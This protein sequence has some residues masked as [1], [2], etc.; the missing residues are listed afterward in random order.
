MSDEGQT[1]NHQTPSGW[2]DAQDSLA[3]ASGLSV[4]LVEGHQPPAL[5][6]SNNN[7]ICH[8][9]QSSPKHV[10]LCDP[11]CGVAFERALKAE[12]VTHYR[13]HAGLHCFAMPVNPG[14]GRQ[15][16]VI[17]GRAFLTSA[18]YRA[19]AERFR[20]G[21]LQDLLSSEIFKNVIFASR[22]DL[23][24]LA[25]RIEEAV[26]ELSGEQRLD[27]RTAQVVVSPPEAVREIKAPEAPRKVK[28]EKQTTDSAA[29][30]QAVSQDANA[31]RTLLQN[32]YFPAESEFKD[33]CSAALEVLSGKHQLTS[34]ALLLRDHGTFIRACGKG[35]FNDIQIHIEI[36]SKDARLF[37][38]ARAGTSLIL[39]ESDEG[40]KPAGTIRKR[41]ADAPERTAE[42]FP[43]IVGDEVKAAILIGDSALTDERRRA[44][45]TYCREIALPLEVLRLRHELMQRVRF[46]EH[47]Q[48]F[49][50]QI[51]TVNPDE[52]YDAILRMST[53]L[54]H[55]ERSSLLL[56]DEA[57]NELAV[58]AAVGPRADVAKETRVRMGEGISGSVLFDGRPL[59]V[60]DVE[61]GGHTPA[62]EERDYKTKSFISYPISIGG[63]KVGVL[64]VTDKAG[65]G[66]YDD[67]DLS[68]IESIAPQMAMA[69]DRAEWQEKANQFQ[70][71]SITD[72]LTGL[73]NRRY[74]IERLAEELKRSKRQEY[75]MSFMMID[76]D[77]F[78]IY[79]DHNGHQAGDLALEMTAQCLKSALRGADVASRYGGEEF[80]I[81]LPQTTLE[82]AT[83]IAE[84]IQRRVLRM[85]F[86]HGKAQPLG[87]VT[88][89]I[90]ISAFQ[91]GVDTPETIIEAAD[92]ALYLAKSRGKN[93]IEPFGS[94]ATE[95]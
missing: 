67:I 46:T 85:H 82:E 26:G 20:V 47:L 71:M 72:P 66:A 32:R 11:Y 84:R 55:A 60:R 90:G 63:R 74:L 56:L 15:L 30:K 48:S 3:A 28:A 76:I 6:V 88:V 68:L 39:R 19:L 78:K 81:L 64:N 41:I 79:N 2:T 57:T 51:N 92:R 34:L 75:P 5:E 16:A 17:G 21:D 91:Q 61:S 58:K 70:L 59:V 94:S 25:R 65:G 95:A 27:E 22:Q 24:D 62:P 40:F 14:V 12:G 7:S 50:E 4:L 35:R 44:I 86:P 54:L 80:C 8:A 53:D 1:Q 10:R 38:T 31:R 23:D 18:D 9:F 87:A 89:S 43:L 73:L 49:G 83:A 29:E 36:G 69:L 13:C 45:S 37:V 77:D 33:A 42:F 52:T 93:R